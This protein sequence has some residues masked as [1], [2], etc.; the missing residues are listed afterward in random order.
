MA[1]VSACGV[2]VAMASTRTPN[3][4]TRKYRWAPLASRA[5]LLAVVRSRCAIALESV[6]T[7]LERHRRTRRLNGE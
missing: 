7:E 6:M 5:R 4:Y 1:R 3:G 2:Q